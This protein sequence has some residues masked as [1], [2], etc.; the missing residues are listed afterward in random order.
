MQLAYTVGYWHKLETLC[1]L[2]LLQD[3]LLCDVDSSHIMV[4]MIIAF[5]ILYALP[6]LWCMFQTTVAFIFQR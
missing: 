6:P 2:F 3:R 1:S 4:A 5:L